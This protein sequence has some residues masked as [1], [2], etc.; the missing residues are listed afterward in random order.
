MVKAEK[1]PNTRL[2]HAREKKG[3]SQARVATAIEAPDE[4]TISRWETGKRVPS[5]HYQEKLCD[6]FGLDSFELGFIDEPQKEK[7]E[8]DPNRR[9]VMLA[10]GAALTGVPF[11]PRSDY[12]LQCMHSLKMCWRLYFNGNSD[13]IEPYLHIYLPQ[14]QKTVQEDTRNRKLAAHLCSQAYQLYTELCTDKEDFGTARSAV[15]QALQYAQV[16]EDNNLY[17][18]ASIRLGNIFFHKKQPKYALNAYEKTTP[19]INTVTPLLRGRTYAGMAEVTGMMQQKSEA[20]SYIGLAKEHYPDKPANDPAFPYT[21]FTQYSLHV[22][23]SGQTHLYLGQ[24]EEAV[25]SFRHADKHIVE[26]HTDP[27]THVDLRYY[28]AQAFSDMGDLEGS[29]HYIEQGVS[30]ARVTGSRLYLSKLAETH[31]G[32]LNRWPH[33]NKVNA[34]EELFF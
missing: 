33:E 1:I 10:I 5:L 12:L 13:I 34:L 21:N 14:L 27:L 32:M 4:A 28:H 17:V 31:Q 16:A 20:L 30:L 23:G 11:I 19:L 7:S 22:F 29:C 26:A 6:L 25:K 8:S 3:W 15:E 9:E 18:A 24:P 2:K